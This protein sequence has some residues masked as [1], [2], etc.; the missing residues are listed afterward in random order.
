M[1]N[2]KFHARKKDNFTYFNIYLTP[3]QKYYLA[4]IDLYSDCFFIQ[5]QLFISVQISR[6]YQVI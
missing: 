4:R 2:A 3:N 6:Y 1:Y 5:I